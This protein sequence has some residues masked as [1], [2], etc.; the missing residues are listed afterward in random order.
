[1]SGTK[2]KRS[3]KK[4]LPE[5]ITLEM[6]PKYVYYNCEDIHN[7]EKTTKREFFRV[8]H[9]KLDKCW[10]STKSCKVSIMDK[11]AQ[12]TKVL[13]DLENDIYPIKTTP[14]LPKYISLVTMR[15]KPHLV[16]EKREEDKRMCLKMV[17]PKD[18][19]LHV[20]LELFNE[21]IK[22]KYENYVLNW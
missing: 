7:E 5:E 16:F 14:A 10:S 18:Y 6:L 22:V 21:K 15:E 3:S 20:Q 17:L 13:D 19:D 2:K 11:L 1:M 8:D 9:P 12:A 4:K